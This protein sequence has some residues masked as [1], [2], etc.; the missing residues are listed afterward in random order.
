[1]WESIL[2]YCCLGSAGVE[3]GHGHGRRVPQ[4]EAPPK[5]PPG[6][7]CIQYNNMPNNVI[8][9]EDKDSAGLSYTLKLAVG[10]QVMFQRNILRE[11]GLVN[12]ARGTTV[13]FTWPEGEQHQP[14]PGALLQSVLV[15]FH[16]PWVRR[17]SHVHIPHMPEVEPVH[18][19]I[20][21][22]SANFYMDRYPWHI[23]LCV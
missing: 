13:G 7:C 10:A 1:M 12:G 14:T 22:V 9:K 5:V 16:D 6:A 3:Q 11:D 17:I 23:S 8:P 15:K 21:L 20:R 2:W 19:G 18:T 4:G